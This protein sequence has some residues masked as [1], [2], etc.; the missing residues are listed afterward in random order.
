[1]LRKLGPF[2][3]K[4]REVLQLWDDSRYTR[5]RMPGSLVP[6]RTDRCKACGQPQAYRSEVSSNLQGN[7]VRVTMKCEA[8]GATWSL[9]RFGPALFHGRRPNG[10]SRN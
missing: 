10:L 1:M 3:P 4:R 8:C 6:D 5:T 2:M 9:R 7:Q